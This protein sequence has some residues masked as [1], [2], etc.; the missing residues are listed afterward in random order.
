MLKLII[1]QNIHLKSNKQKKPCG[2]I[3]I[4]S[5]CCPSKTENFVPIYTNK[6]V[7]KEIL[8]PKINFKN[9]FK[10]LFI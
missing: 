3:A 5:G 7:V 10:N 8:C 9:H 1:E 4:R 6:L 2:K